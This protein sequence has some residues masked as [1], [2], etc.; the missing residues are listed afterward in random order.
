MQCEQTKDGTGCTTVGVCGKTPEVANLQD[1]LIYQL[2]GLACWA[3]LGRQH[4]E[5]LVTS[6]L[7]FVE[8]NMV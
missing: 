8:F 1:L 4:G 7:H 2:K 3:N 5:L 6:S